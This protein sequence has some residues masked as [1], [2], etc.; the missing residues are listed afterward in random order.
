MREL[1]I[2]IFST[3]VFGLLL[4]FSFIGVHS[5]TVRLPFFY[6]PTGLIANFDSEYQNLWGNSLS[7]FDI[8]RDSVESIQNKGQTRDITIINEQNETI[9][10]SFELIE[11]RKLDVIKIFYLDLFLAFFSLLTAVY[12]YYSTRD[13]LIFSFFLNLSLLLFSNVFLLTYRISPSPLFFSIYLSAFINYHLIFRLRGKEIP[14][15]WILPQILIALGVAIV[16]GQ[17]NVD[18][19][20][21]DRMVNIGYG[22]TVIFCLINIFL[23][24]KDLIENKPSGDALIKRITLIF[25]IVLYVSVPLSVIVLNGHPWFFVDRIFFFLTYLLFI[26]FFCY[27]TYKYTFIPSFVIFTPTIITLL[28]VTISSV[29]YISLLLLVDYFLPLPYVKERWFLNLILLFLLT[30]Y[31][32]PIKLRIK[33]LID[34]WFFETNPVLSHGI[35]TITKLITEPISMRKTISSINKTVMETLNVSNIIILIPGDQ[36]ART[37]LRNVNFMRIP[38]QSEIWNYFANTDRVTVTS[39]LEYGIGLRETLFSFLKGLNVQLAFPAF[40]YSSNKKVVRAMILLGEKGDSNYFSI[41]E[42]K[43]INEVVK[44]TAMLIEN[45]SLLEDEIQK[46]KIVRDIQTASIVDNT[47]RIIAPSEIKGID[48]G[49]LN[50]PAVGISG[51]YLDII[52]ISNTKIII[53]LGDVAGHGLGT[54]FLV[55]AIKGIVREHL[56]NGTSLEGL[57]KEINSFFRARYKGSEFM[58]LLGGLID[59]E[60]KTFTFINAGHLALLQMDPSGQLITHAKTQ[61]VLGILETDYQSQQLQLK[62][63]TKLFLFTDGITETFGKNDELFGEEML[64]DFLKQNNGLPIKELPS[65]LSEKLDLFRGARDLTDDITFIAL[66]FVTD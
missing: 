8:L 45:Y 65:I 66:S 20:I 31:M 21:L 47:L 1:S 19:H 40:G 25:A 61:R 43:F 55:S 64:I 30:N 53:L 9:H 7:E 23:N 34:Y 3:L 2:T 58:T 36:F 44:I 51:D 46:R 56:R 63:G 39:H 42:L 17:E 10:K 12:F 22:L 32:I 33:E 59:S 13:G 52:P 35:E 26:I 18:F 27:G 49:Y 57:F 11:F 29:L 48:F 5:T 6:Y 41:G 4:F 28:L 15:K 37:D 14:S 24:F 50:R 16:A 62:S 38:S 60:S 54:G